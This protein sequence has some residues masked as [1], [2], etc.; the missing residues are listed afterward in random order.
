VLLFLIGV[1]SWIMILLFGLAGAAVAGSASGTAAIL[2]R[3][4]FAL[5][6]QIL[7]APIGAVAMIL[8]YYD[9][10]IRKEGFDLAMLAQQ[11]GKRP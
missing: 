7:A 4:I 8:L 3:G 1:I 9:L 10:R 5:V 6:A 11:L 2:G